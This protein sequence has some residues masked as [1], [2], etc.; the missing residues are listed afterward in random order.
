ARP[1]RLAPRGR[2]IAATASQDHASQLSAAGLADRAVVPRRLEVDVGMKRGGVASGAAAAQLASCIHQMPGLRFLGVMGWEGHAVPL[3]G[4]QKQLEI[5]AAMTRLTDSS[6]A[7]RA[8]G[9]PVEIVSAGGSGTYMLSPPRAGL[10]EVQA[11]G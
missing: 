7:C 3:Q 8:A 9:L 1:G 11:G 10:T 2:A 5:A 4:E 6:E